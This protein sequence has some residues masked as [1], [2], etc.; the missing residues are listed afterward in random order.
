M[1]CQPTMGTPDPATA[2][3]GVKEAAPTYNSVAGRVHRGTTPH[4]KERLAGGQPKAL[5]GARC[6]GVRSLLK[7]VC[8]K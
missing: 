6:P 5:S 3:I 1:S 2:C 7:P 4:S 8:L